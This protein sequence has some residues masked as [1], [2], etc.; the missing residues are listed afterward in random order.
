MTVNLESAAVEVYLRTPTG[1]VPFG[2][3]SLSAG[4]VEG[5]DQRG[6]TYRGTCIRVIDLFNVELTASVPAGTRIADD[7]VTETTEERKL[8]FCLNL[9]HVAGEQTK[10]IMLAGFGSADVRF[11][12]S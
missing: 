12:V 4:Q 9:D 11:E 3:F 6:I 1:D 5:T 10:S 7:L 2:R 8:A